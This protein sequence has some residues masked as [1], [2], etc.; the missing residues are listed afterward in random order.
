LNSTEGRDYD[1][2]PGEVKGFSCLSVNVKDFNGATVPFVPVCY[3][4]TQ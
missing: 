4:L 1:L 3:V 2:P